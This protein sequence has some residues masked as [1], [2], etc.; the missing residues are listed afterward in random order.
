MRGSSDVPPQILEWQ[1]PAQR[2]S[3]SLG[4]NAYSPATRGRAAPCRRN[5]TDSDTRAGTSTAS[6]LS[7]RA[8]IA[9]LASAVLT[10]GATRP[11]Q[12]QNHGFAPVTDT[13][14]QHP[15]PADW[16]MWRRTLDSWG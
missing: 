16:L 1:A 15:D 11:S 14:L 8:W 10:I 4:S 2:G 7:F 13:V 5:L 12:A 9:I 6:S 3:T